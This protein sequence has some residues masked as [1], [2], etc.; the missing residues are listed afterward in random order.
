MITAWLLFLHIASLVI[1]CAALFYLP[2]VFN[3][4]RNLKR[5]SA[6]RLRMMTRFAF[7]GLASPAA[8]L[9]IITGTALV[10]FTQASGS[11]LAAKLLLVALMAAFHVYCGH[12]LTLLGHEG[13]HKQK[14]RGASLG[15][16]VVPVLLI[17]GVLWLVLAK[18]E[19]LANIN[20]VPW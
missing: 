17:A 11:W 10:Y 15:M 8:V 1:W 19:L 7:I 20:G 4:N 14:R 13:S 9:A 16:I 5:G 3:A 2:V 12:T 18:P 6:R